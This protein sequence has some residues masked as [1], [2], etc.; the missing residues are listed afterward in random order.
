MKQVYSPVQIG[1]GTYLGGPFA[2]MYFLKSNFDA[3][4]K[5]DYSKM[6]IQIGALVSVLLFLILP[7][8]P[9]SFPNNVIPIAYLIPV[10]LVVKKHQL[11]KEDISESEEYDFQSSWKA[12]GLSVLSLLAFFVMA[13][14][15]LFSFDSLGLITL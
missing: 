9:E 12:F 10:L 8:L 2:A 7:F 5:H 4:E 13:M 1:I 11:T 6:T 15:V 3:L 14:A